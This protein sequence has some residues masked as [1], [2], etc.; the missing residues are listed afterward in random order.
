MPPAHSPLKEAGGEHPRPRLAPAKRR[1]PGA[2]TPTTGE[3]NGGE[4]AAIA[5]FELGLVM[6]RSP[7]KAGMKERHGRPGTTGTP[8]TRATPAHHGGTPPREEEGSYW[9]AGQGLAF[10]FP[11]RARP[12]QPRSESGLAWRAGGR[13]EWCGASH[14]RRRR[15]KDM[16]GLDQSQP[17]SAAGR[18]DRRGRS[19][20]A[21]FSSSSADLRCGA[22]KTGPPVPILGPSAHAQTRGRALP[23]SPFPRSLAPLIR[24]VAPHSLPFPGLP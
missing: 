21:K 2:I 1:H 6:D 10:G 18:R 22:K 8:W 24:Y 12:V 5:I 7:P 13:D 16:R 14:G 3:C 20:A 19:S 15:S 4:S 11:E 17:A 23:P 9:E